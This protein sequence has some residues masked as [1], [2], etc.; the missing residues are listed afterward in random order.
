MS[1][2]GSLAGRILLAMQ[3]RKVNQARL[4]EGLGTS[5]STVSGWKT[6]AALPDAA[7][8]EQ[9]PGLLRISG[10]WL[11]TGKGEMDEPGAAQTEPFELARLEVSAELRRRVLFALEAALANGP[12]ADAIAARRGHAAVQK[13]L[14]KKALPPAATRRRK[15]GG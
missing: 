14:E 2:V 1:I 13:A 9:L 8:L 6:G 10:H 7:A 4:A 12:P 5:Q 3:I 15:G 11:L